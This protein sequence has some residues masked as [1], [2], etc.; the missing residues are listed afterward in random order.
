MKRT[1]PIALIN[2]LESTLK[3][4]SHLIKSDA[5]VDGLLVKITEKY[6]EK[7]PFYFFIVDFKAEKDAVYYNVEY[8]PCSSEHLNPLSASLPTPQVQLHLDAWIK[9]L[10]EYAKESIV[11]DDPIT[12]S[13]Y[14]EIAPN[15]QILDDDADFAPIKHRDQP[16]VHLLY[17]E[18]KRLVAGKINEKNAKEAEA[19]IEEINE[20]K[21][22]LSKDTKSKAFDRFRWITA[23]VMTFSHE[24]GKAII[25]DILIRLAASAI[26]M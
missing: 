4:N 17:E 8:T 21:D 7:S 19:I 22:Q 6:V 20:A 1:V 18:T 16:V 23:K 14:D 24:A 11:F 12:K 5:A 3:A 13:Y 9:F 10:E 25:T 26:G 2:I 15:F